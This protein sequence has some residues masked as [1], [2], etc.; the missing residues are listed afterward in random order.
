MNVLDLVAASGGWPTW[1]DIVR[2]A[3]L[4]DYNT[5]LVILT[6]AALGC[7]CGMIGTFLLL[8]KRSLIGDAIAHATLPGVVVA[9]LIMV[10][11]EGTGKWLPGLLAGAALSGLLGCGLV[12]AVRHMTRIK[13]DAAIGIALSVFFGAGIVLLAMVQNLPQG[14][15]AGLEA[16]IY[17]K[18]ASIIAADSKFLTGISALV[19]VSSVLFFKEFRLLCFD[20]QFALALG[21]PVLFLD[22]MLMALVTA[23][24]VAGLQAVGLIL[25]IAL[26]II[27]AAAARFW[28]DRTSWMLGL[29][30]AMGAA[31]GW[32]GA[33]LSALA[34]RLPAGAIIV[35]V[36][37]VL[38]LASMLFGTC[39]GVLLH[40]KRRVGMERRVRRQ[41]LL[42]AMFEA[43][44]ARGLSKGGLQQPQPVAFEDLLAR[45]TWSRQ[46]LAKLVRQAWRE[47]LVEKPAGESVRLTLSGLEEARKV[48]RNHRLWETYLIRYADIAPSHVDRDADAVEHILGEEMVRELEAALAEKSPI[49][50]DAQIPN[51]PHPLHL[52]TPG[53]TLR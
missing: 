33:S 42:R 53:E 20:A 37:A 14:N 28:T 40:L 12:L 18:T 35:L 47:D 39:R 27:P 44:E 2:V 52:R 15:K 21:L 36:A 30:G 51:S 50:A 9:F 41:H 11:L 45:R 38:F 22:I 13:D 7:A 6:I 23:M 25:I 8:R 26:L 31:S 5:R 32:A 1:S 3:L 29:S 49:S 10:A 43:M 17:G 48:T 19:I 16:F 24:T 34:P 46:A 4:R